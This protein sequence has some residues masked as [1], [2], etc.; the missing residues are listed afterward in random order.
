MR[1]KRRPNN[2]FEHSHHN[3][4]EHGRMDNVELLQV[5]FV[6]SH[7]ETLNLVYSTKGQTRQPTFCQM[8]CMQ[9]IAISVPVCCYCSIHNE[10]RRVCS[11]FPH[12]DLTWISSTYMY[13]QIIT[14]SLHCECYSSIRRTQAVHC[15]QYCDGRE[16]DRLM[17]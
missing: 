17:L 3:L 4:D 6:P 2:W 9:L 7:S 8:L 14:I 1:S 12:M 13:I 15:D 10:N 16:V 5:L 11:R